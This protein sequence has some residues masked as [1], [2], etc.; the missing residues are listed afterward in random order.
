MEKRSEKNNLREEY[1]DRFESFLKPAAKELQSYLKSLLIDQARV[2]RITA[3]A[4][5]VDSFVKKGV[6]EIE[7]AFV[8]K[9]PISQIQDQIGARVVVFYKDDVDIVSDV[10]RN[11]FRSIEHVEII[12]ESE[13]EFGYMGVHFV[14]HCPRDIF[15]DEVTRSQ[16]PRF[17]ELQIKTPYQHAWSEANHDLGYKSKVQLNSEQKRSIA[18]TAAQSWG[19]DEIFN[20]LHRTHAIETRST[21]VKSDTPS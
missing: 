7:G 12:P 21:S 3:R 13:Q 5:S 6:K 11:N 20:A 19:A 17:F 8:Y 1:A 16:N 4:K 14:L 2:D 18:F 9:D 15:P 10:I